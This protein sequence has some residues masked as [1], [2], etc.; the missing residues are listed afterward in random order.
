MT[1]LYRILTLLPLW[2]RQLGVILLW[3]LGVI[4]LWQVYAVALFTSLLGRGIPRVWFS[5]CWMSHSWQVAKPGFY[6]GPLTTKSTLL[7]CASRLLILDTLCKRRS[8]WEGRCLEIG[9]FRVLRCDKTFSAICWTGKGFYNLALQWKI[10]TI[11]NFQSTAGEKKSVGIGIWRRRALGL[12]AGFRSWP[13]DLQAE[14]N[15]S[16][17]QY[18]CL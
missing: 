10:N 3:Q 17:P 15:L 14:V 9:K 5:H 6:L 16:T 4:L 1:Q 18:S 13:H 7:P 2:P 11:G 8:R 12:K